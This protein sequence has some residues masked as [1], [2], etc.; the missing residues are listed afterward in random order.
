MA[1]E[2]DAVPAQ[3]EG[4]TTLGLYR[5]IAHQIDTMRIAACRLPHSAGIDQGHEYQAHVPEQ[6]VQASVPGQARKQTA[7]KTQQ[8]LRTYALQTMNP[9]KESDGRQIGIRVAQ[10]QLVHRKFFAV[11]TDFTRNIDFQMSPAK[12]QQAFQLS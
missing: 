7:Q 2:T 3:Q 1:L 12:F 11:C 8:H 5:R 9:P 4:Y 10:G 6:M